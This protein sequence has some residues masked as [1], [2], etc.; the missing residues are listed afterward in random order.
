VSVTVTKE[1]YAFKPTTRGATVY[2]GSGGGDNSLTAVTLNS[3]VVSK[4]SNGNTTELKLTFSDTITGLTDNHI[5]ITNPAN[6]WA[7]K[8][9]KLAGD[10]N[11]YTLPVFVPQS[12]DVTVVVSDPEGYVISGS[13]QSVRVTYSSIV[14]TSGASDNPSIKAKFGIYAEGTDGVTAAFKALSAYIKTPEFSSYNNV[15]KLGDWIDLDGGLTVDPYINYGT[16]NMGNTSMYPDFK[17]DERMMLRLIVVGIN[18]F[19]NKNENDTTPH[20]V[21]HFQNAL[22][23]HP[24]NIK[25]SGNPTNAGGYPASTLRKYLIPV[26]GDGNSGKFLAGLKNAGVPEEVLWAPQRFVL[27]SQTDGEMIQDKLWVPTLYEMTGKN[28]ARE[29]NNVTV[30]LETSSNQAKLEYYTSSTLLDKNRKKYAIY[31][32]EVIERNYWLASPYPNDDYKFCI[33]NSYSYKGLPTNI[34]AHYVS[35]VV[36]AFCVQ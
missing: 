14:P 11:V 12:G 21:F 10:G 13:P 26:V 7:V 24:M 33:V 17:F 22:V 27:K 34:E 16:I 9:G 28:Q 25:T 4:T 5:T 30:K 18:S 1:G 23:Y 20:V 15:I 35:G 2:S 8:N 32:G 19:K 31:I 36:P 29:L 3:V 6:G